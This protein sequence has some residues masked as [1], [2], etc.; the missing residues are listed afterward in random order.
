MRVL[1]VHPH[2][3]YDPL[4]PWTIRITSLARCLTERGHE[5]KLAYHIA[6]PDRTPAELRD[7]QE[8]PFEVIPFV[9]HMGLG[10]RKALELTELGR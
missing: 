3:I 8:F 10:L 2:D 5:V 7:R 1:M 9:R 4:E 6:R